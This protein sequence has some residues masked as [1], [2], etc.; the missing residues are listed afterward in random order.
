MGLCS[1]KISYIHSGN[2]VAK[3]LTFV[4]TI[5]ALERIGSELVRV[6]T[7]FHI[8]E[9]HRVGS[10]LVKDSKK[11]E[12]LQIID[13]KSDAE[14]V[15]L[16][17]VNSFCSTD[18]FESG[19]W[20]TF[21]GLNKRATN[22][23]DI[24]LEILKA[25]IYHGADPKGMSTHGNRTCLMFAVLANDYGFTKQLVE[26]GVDINQK[27]RNGETA[28]GLAIELK[29][30]DIASYLRSKG[31]VEVLTAVSSKGFKNCLKQPNRVI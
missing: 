31:A 21:D 20:C 19:D 6:S 14:T 5:S 24:G 8:S 26:L 13:N 17:R 7:K 1:S 25:Q 29:R 27:N 30:D 2:E 12:D 4:K 28:L 15:T 16:P 23:H 9:S 22:R 3:R 10:E 18:S 11:P